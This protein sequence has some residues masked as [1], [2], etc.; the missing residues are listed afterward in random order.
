M[1]CA[2]LAGGLG[3][4]LRPRTDKVP[5]AMVEVAGRPF[6]D[7]QVELLAR[8]GVD[9]LVLCVG[10]LG[11][12]VEDHLGDGK[13]RGVKI[14][15][16]RDGPELLGPAGALKRA[17]GLLGEMFFV[18][19]GDA[20]L[21]APYAAVME[22]LASS[23]DL[24]LMTVFRNEGRYGPSD[25]DVEAGRVVRYEKT[26]RPGEMAWVNFGLSALRKEALAII[27]PGSPYGEV[28]FYGAMIGRG[29]LGAFE[30]SERFFEIGTPASLAEFEGFITGGRRRGQGQE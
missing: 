19:Y 30:V 25:V 26:H 18:T 9:D 2:I 24:G 7:Y 22:K 1:Q 23:G 6:I 12:L 3:T 8:N 27:P 16:S 11:E 10:Y 14:R 5:K 20:Y 4:R 17:V 13:G 21:R 15:Y 28:E 29:K